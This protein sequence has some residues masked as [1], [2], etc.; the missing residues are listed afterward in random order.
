MEVIQVNKDSFEAYFQNTLDKLKLV[1]LR[2]G[3]INI[4]LNNQVDVTNFISDLHRQFHYEV[5]M[6]KKRLKEN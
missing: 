6:L 3:T 5:C 4:K 1:S 2:E